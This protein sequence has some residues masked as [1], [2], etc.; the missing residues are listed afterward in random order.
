MA[1]PEMESEHIAV[2][3]ERSMKGEVIDESKTK[4]Q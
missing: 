2:Q 3:L 4:A 1:G